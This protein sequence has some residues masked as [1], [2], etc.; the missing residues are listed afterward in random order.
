MN[1]FAT[2][3]LALKKKQAKKCASKLEALSS[4]HASSSFTEDD[5]EETEDEVQASST[6]CNAFVDIS[7]CI[8]IIVYIIKFNE[9]KLV[10]DIK[11]IHLGEFKVH[12]YNAMIIKIVYKKIK[13]TKIDF[14]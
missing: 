8:F 1:T 4:H 10:L 5:D 11:I 6:Q 2:A 7:K 12:D 13:K 9:K 14:E 3:I